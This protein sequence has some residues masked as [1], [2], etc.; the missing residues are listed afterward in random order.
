MPLR[1]VKQIRL[2]RNA[3]LPTKTCSKMS[4]LSDGAVWSM[5]HNAMCKGPRDNA[6][7]HERGAST[8]ILPQNSWI[9]RVLHAFI[10][11]RVG[12]C[13]PGMTWVVIASLLYL[14]WWTLCFS[15]R[16]KNSHTYIFE[17][18]LEKS[19]KILIVNITWGEKGRRDSVCIFHLCCGMYLNMN[20]KGKLNRK[21]SQYSW[22]L[23][24]VE[25]I[26]SSRQNPSQM[27]HGE[28]KAMRIGR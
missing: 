20:R 15:I 12:P 4:Q 18:T 21:S 5:S 28:S 24:L 16:T 6:A 19:I 3:G 17:R 8:V 23:L 10:D 25:K 26:Q 7:G 2:S 27:D 11:K 9:R 22:Y 13:Q 1:P 14:V